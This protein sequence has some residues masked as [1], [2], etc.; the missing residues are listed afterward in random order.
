[1]ARKSGKPAW[2]T[3]R[4]DLWAILGQTL[5]QEAHV[6][7]DTGGCGAGTPGPPRRPRVPPGGGTDRHLQPHVP[8]AV[9]GRRLPDVQ[10]GESDGD[11]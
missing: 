6:L 11:V 3:V 2:H 9:H 4:W 8:A 5:Q 7:T 1:M 10:C